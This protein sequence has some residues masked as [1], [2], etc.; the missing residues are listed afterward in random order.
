MQKEVRIPYGALIEAATPRE[1]ESMILARAQA[2]GIP[3]IGSTFL[4]ALDRGRL[5]IRREADRSYIL[6]WRD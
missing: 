4:V 6:T 1:M 5:E 3:L 2:A